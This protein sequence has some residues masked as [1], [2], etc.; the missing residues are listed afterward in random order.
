MTAARETDQGV[1]KWF[2]LSAVSLG[3]FMATLNTSIVNISLPTIAGNFGVGISDIEWVVVAFL[4]AAGALLLTFGRLGDLAGYKRVYLVGFVIFT[5]AGTLRGLSQGVGVLVGL[6]TL[7]GVGAGMVQAIGP[8][9][10]TSAFSP[11][12]RGKALGLNA[13]SVAV[14]L[15]LGPTLGGILTQWLSWRWIFY[16]NLP[17]GAFGVLWAFRILRD[18]RRDVRQ[19]FDSRGGPDLRGAPGAP[20]GPDR[21]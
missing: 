5:L 14:G 1:S 19:Q 4:L 11:T 2:V 6:R 18:E 3:T 17:V 16:V 10:V 8:A 13:M 21:R 20:P 12:E 7:Q 9:I 15:G